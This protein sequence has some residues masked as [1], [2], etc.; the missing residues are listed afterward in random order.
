[1]KKS[2]NVVIMIWIFEEPIWLYNE[3]L[4]FF[5]L[6]MPLDDIVGDEDMLVPTW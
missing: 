2:T 4:L 6:N 3:S 5:T 1:M